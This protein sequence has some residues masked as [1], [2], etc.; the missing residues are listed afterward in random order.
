MTTVDA[1]SVADEG[2][3]EPWRTVMVAS[4]E[5]GII[6][7]INVEQGDLV[8]KGDVLC[9]LDCHVLKV[10]LLAAELKLAA[11]GELEAAQSTLENKRHHL[12]QMKSLLQRNHASEQEVKQAQLEFELAQ[13][14]Q[15]TAESDV[16]RNEIEVQKIK[17]QIDRRVIRS[18]HRGVVLDLPHEV[19]E[20]VTTAES[21]VATVVQLDLL[22][23]RYF[24]TTQQAMKMKKGGEANLFFPTSNQT[25][26]AKVDFI[27]P[28]TDSNS[29]T[30]RVELMIDNR[31]LQYRSGLRCIL[32]QAE[33]SVATDEYHR[34]IHLN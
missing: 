9:R 13:A 6:T 4:A 34:S 23:V 17:A 30:V 8:E 32:K 29:G 31:K 28:V 10:A 20:S 14:N 1:Q 16:Q 11:T 18:Q 33:A 19:G 25:A 21:H 22:R 12:E 7:E 24:L 5:S 15:K 3:T 26:K 27:S 2:F